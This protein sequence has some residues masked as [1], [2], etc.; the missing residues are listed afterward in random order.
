MKTFKAIILIILG[1]FFIATGFAFAGESAFS[2]LSSGGFNKSSDD[3][4][5]YK[6]AGIPPASGPAE[7]KSAPAPAPEPTVGQKIKGWIGANKSKMAL[8]GV[9]AFLGYAIVGTALGACTFGLG[10]L[11]L[12]VLAA[13]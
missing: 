6:S 10:F 8:I 13:A 11:L 2:Q 5:G 7:V 1:T 9:G 4:S 12:M 3:M